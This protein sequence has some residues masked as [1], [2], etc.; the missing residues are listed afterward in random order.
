MKKQ[1]KCRCGRLL[2]GRQRVNCSECYIRQHP[3]SSQCAWK[4]CLQWFITHGGSSYTKECLFHS[5]GACKSMT[6]DEYCKRGR[7]KVAAS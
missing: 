2:Q 4:W 1:L 6:Y 5:T 7:R 3:S